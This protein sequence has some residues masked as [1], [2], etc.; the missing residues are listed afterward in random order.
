MKLL[1]LAFL[2]ASP[3]ISPTL[4]AQENSASPGMNAKGEEVVVDVI[5]RD[6]KGRAITNLTRSDFSVFDDG[7]PRPVQSFRFV[8]GVAAA[9]AANV[10]GSSAHVDPLR[11]IRLVSLIFDRMGIDGRRLSGQAALDLLKENLPQNVYMAVFSLDRKLEALQSFTNNRDLLR[12]AVEHA[13]SGG[14]T[15]FGSDSAGI[16]KQVEQELLGPN[17]S[18]KLSL[19]ERADEMASPGQ[20]N[21][22]PDQ[23]FAKVM[24][25]ML[26]FDQ[27][28]DAIQTGRSSIFGLL[29]AVQGQFQLPGRKT[30]LYFADGFVIPQGMEEPFQTLISTA[31]RNNV[32]FYSIDA[33]GLISDQMNG[34]AISQLSRAAIASDENGAGQPIGD[35][36]ITAESARSADTAIVSGRYN[37]QDTLATLAEQTGG[38]LVANTN[39][40]RGPLHRI[41]EEI[42]SYYELTYSPQIEKYDGSFRKINV[43]TSRSDLRVQ[44]RSGYFAL[45]SAVLKGGSPLSAF[46][47]PLLRALNASPMPKAFAFESEGLHYR[48][49]GHNQIM[50]FVIDLPLKNLTVSKNA[51]TGTFDGGLSYIAL[52]KNEAGEVV[53]KLQGDA[54]V[55]LHDDQI[56]AFQQS[57]FTDAEYFDVPPGRYTVEA[58]VLD[59]SS[60]RTSAQKSALFVPKPGTELALSSVTLI[61]SWKAKEPDADEEDPFIYGDKAVTPT[62]TPAVSK[63]SSNSLPF[64]FIIYPDTSKQEKPEVFVEFLRDGKSRRVGSS[65]VGAP[66]AE[67]RI[68]YVATAPIE[69]FEP[70]KYDVRFLVRQGTETAQEGFSLNLEP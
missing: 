45:P 23:L 10:Q 65:P 11:Q 14:Y 68:R 19:E 24:I 39:D 38:F 59:R 12:K 57:R 51:A 1:L 6:K 66:D 43:K 62:L 25:Q 21:N 7:K 15:E 64:Y 35:N 37:T 67:G 33:R 70:G 5:V 31:N 27:E 8:D 48:S 29:A 42:E 16:E 61:R 28:A 46:D 50:G 36:H 55:Q 56:G 52:I 69:P 58:A 54:P 17:V 4:R 32:S 13:T 18:G 20:F 47:V 26:R 41:A 63:G 30:I 60:G 49:E 3:G 22:S 40:F 53:K 2:I 34:R 44:S 9:S